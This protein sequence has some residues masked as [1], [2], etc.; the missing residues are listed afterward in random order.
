MNWLK[1]GKWRA[2]LL[3]AAPCILIY[4]FAHHRFASGIG[5]GDPD[6]YFHLALARETV[7]SGRWFLRQ[8]P[9]ITGLG[10]ERVFP[11]KEFLFHFINRGL[12]AWGGEAGVLKIIPIAASAILMVLS[13]LVQR[14][15]RPAIGAFI[16]SLFVLTDPW[17]LIRLSMLRPHL[18]A[19]LFFC[20]VLYALLR[21]SAVGLF[22]FGVLYSWSYHSFYVPLI[23]MGIFY[24]VDLK[25]KSPKLRIVVWGALGLLTG[26]IVH[27]YFPWNLW[28]S[29]RHAVI[30][31]FEASN[32]KLDFGVELFPWSTEK[33]LRLHLPYFYILVSSPFVVLL[34]VEKPR[35]FLR[36]SDFLWLWA[37]AL[38]FLALAAQNPRALEYAIPIGV[39]LMALVAQSFGQSRRRTT[40]F[41]VGLALAAIPR[42][43]QLSATLRESVDPVQRSERLEKLVSSL[44]ALPATPEGQP[45]RTHLFNVEWDQPPYV[46]YAR[47]DFQFIDILDPSF[48]E[49]HDKRLHSVRWMLRS[50][51]VPDPWGVIQSLTRSRFVLSRYPD[52]NAQL[53][54]DLNFKRIF[55]KVGEQTVGVPNLFELL[56]E[57]DP[58]FV[59]EW[60]AQVVLLAGAARTADSL[61]PVSASDGRERRLVTWHEHLER[62][63]AGITVPAVKSAY[64]DLRYGTNVKALGLQSGS[65]SVGD[66]IS[67]VLVEPSREER[68]RQVGKNVL[69]L[70]G[71]RSLRVWLN[72]QKFFRSVAARE[73]IQL[74]D[75]LVPIGRSLTAG[76]RV[77]IIVCSKDSAPSLGVSLSFWTPKEI[78]DRCIERGWKPAEALQ[79]SKSWPRVGAYRETCLGAYVRQR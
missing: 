3:G 16:V 75:R 41:L 66:G 53:A 29:F 39:V 25:W 15:V 8:I 45:E 68:M 35:E 1:D 19:I 37:S 14:F 46:Y 28:M 76:D 47:P 30:A 56:P 40:V 54:S 6:R 5:V 65:D 78:D 69:V 27:P 10:W 57:R 44:R 11:D 24:A 55:P 22:I 70:G 42:G 61:T 34:G 79:D 64:L 32:S 13:L 67:C 43:M 49:S 17:L 77:Q 72:G 73:S 12:Y 26:L 74:T 18:L 52:V 36:K 2:L 60:S 71:G 9:Q 21:R 38:V 58:H 48:L 59:L 63:A 23:L 4:L 62:E 31:L 51:T 33:F 20:G 7:A 50:G